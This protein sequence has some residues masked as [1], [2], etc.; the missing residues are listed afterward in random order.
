MPGTPGPRIATT[1]TRATAT[2]TTASGPLAELTAKW[3]DARR[4]RT[5][6]QY[7]GHD[8]SSRTCALRQCRGDEERK[9][10][11]LAGR[12]SDEWRTSSPEVSNSGAARDRPQRRRQPPGPHLHGGGAALPGD[13]RVRVRGALAPHR[14]LRE[15]GPRGAKRRLGPPLDL[16][17]PAAQDLLRPRA[18]PAAGATA[19]WRFSRRQTTLDDCVGRELG[20]PDTSFLI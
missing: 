17:E 1:T 8:Q 18:R 20:Y 15:H 19:T 4:S 16:L 10:A 6:S 12:A 13:D 3:S 11:A 5:P 2:T 14:P 7:P 9:R